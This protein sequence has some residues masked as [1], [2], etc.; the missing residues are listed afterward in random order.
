M[1]TNVSFALNPATNEA[2]VPSEMLR[3][4][5]TVIRSL[6]D[7]MLIYGLDKIDVG[8]QAHGNMTLL[9]PRVRP[10]TVIDVPIW[11]NSSRKQ[12]MLHLSHVMLILGVLGIEVELDEKELNDIKVRWD[13]C[14]QLP[15]TVVDGKEQVGPL[16][17][18]EEVSDVE[19]K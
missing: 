8:Q 4:G 15:V 17:P 11:L 2:L 7:I 6:V 9:N 16:L 12:A 14:E 5:S 19:S 13:S 3:A 10:L 18:L 1:K